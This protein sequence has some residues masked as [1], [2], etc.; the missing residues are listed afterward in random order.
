MDTKLA[1]LRPGLG[2][3]APKRP[4]RTL[5]EKA[6]GHRQVMDTWLVQIARDTGHQLATH[7]TGLLAQWPGH[8]VRVG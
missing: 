7:D 4:A 2:V 5:L 1:G 6:T 8:T 3:V